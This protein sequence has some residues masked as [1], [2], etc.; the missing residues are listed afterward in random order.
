MAHARGVTAHGA[1]LHRTQAVH[2]TSRAVVRQWGAR[3][4]AERSEATQP[5]RRPGRKFL[6]ATGQARWGAGPQHAADAAGS[7]WSL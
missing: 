2:A 6:G 7:A 5:M 4:Q 1:H 3:P